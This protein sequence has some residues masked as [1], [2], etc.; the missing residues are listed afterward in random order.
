MKR[1]TAGL[2][3]LLISPQT[4]AAQE[5]FHGSAARTGVYS[6]PG[7]KQLGGVKWAFKT[8]G[9][10]VSSPA[11][12]GGL[13][14]VGSLDTNLYA[15]DQETGAQKWRFKTEGPVA[16]SPAVADGTVYFG[17]NDGVFYA[18]A[19]DTGAVRWRFATERG[20]RRFEAKGLHGTRPRAQTAPDP[21]DL[22]TSSPAVYGNRV[23]F[24]SGDGNVYAL[25]AQTGVLQWKF[26]TGEVVRASPAVVNN[27]VY[28]GSW[29]SYL[30]ALDAETG[31]E[32]WRF[33][34]GEDPVNHN[35]VGFQSSPAVVD[36]VLY[37]G[38]RD[39]HVYALDAA[40]G[41]K[42]WDYYTSKAWVMG[43]PAVGGGA[44]Y[45][46]TGD[47]R[48]FL[49]L[50]AKTGRLRFSL[51]T[52]TALFSSPALAGEMIYVGALN[53]RLYAVDVKEGKLAWEFQTE[54]S[55][56]DPLKVLNPDGTRNQAGFT[57]TF[58]DFQ[59]MYVTWY[60]YFSVGAIVSSPVVDRGVVYFGGTDGF[61]YALR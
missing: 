15:V 25:D 36:G 31:V 13:V 57:P 61:L 9:A 11:V 53:G 1:L 17:G 42:K 44:V 56:N 38:C 54:S 46:G 3:L 14:F 29:D 47:T 23:Y 43:T 21:F 55:R 16:S 51:D 60:R 35:Q 18:L 33:K 12:S 24:G 58:F 45:V 2:C 48:K 30:Y 39:A 41:R 7:P 32:R 52:K 50:D 27:T 59:D 20:E 40:T 5:T 6:S 10:V 28:V 37:V 8:D 22:F 4:A 19:A 34:T 26:S 49:A